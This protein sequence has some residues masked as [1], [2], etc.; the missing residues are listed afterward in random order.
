MFR[1]ELKYMTVNMRQAFL[2]LYFGCKHNK[3]DANFPCRY[4][5]THGQ[6]YWLIPVTVFP[7]T[8]FSIHDLAY[9]ADSSVCMLVPS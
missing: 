3:R 4:I 6:D 2:Y 9:P 8:K 7:S 5:P 1:H